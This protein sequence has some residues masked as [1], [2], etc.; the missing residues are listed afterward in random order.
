MTIFMCGG[1]F[2]LPLIAHTQE[3]CGTVLYHK[4]Q[5]EKGLINENI[6]DFENWLEDKILEKK[7][8]QSNLGRTEGEIY[9]IPVV[10]HVIHNGESLGIVRNI[11]TEQ[12]LSQIDILN[13]DF[14][15][16]NADASE[17]PESFLP[18]AEDMEIEFV[19]A[20]RDPEGLPTDGIVR[21]QGSQESWSMADNYAL[22]SQSYWPAEDYLNIWVASIS[23]NL[24][25]YAQFPVSGLS[26]L[27]DASNNRLTD[28]IVVD[29]EY[30]GEGYNTQRL[31]Q[32]T[33]SYT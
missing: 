9:Q 10:I 1:F 19:L 24:L 15:R 8:S 23:G 25:G 13:E 31:Q 3:K 5:L 12:I 28:G 26:G 17:T 7:A 29:F 16:L 32:R 18:V 33:D 4:E 30:F 11:P 6:P 20:K 27:E 22:K 2:L 14:R 21:V